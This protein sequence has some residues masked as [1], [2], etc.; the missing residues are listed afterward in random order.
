MEENQTN[1]NL[2]QQ[3]VQP[4]QPQPEQVQ[5]PVQ[6]QPQ[7]AQPVEEPTVSMQIQQLLVQQQQYQQ[8]YNQLVDYVKKTPN[9]PIEQVNQIKAQL[10][11]LNA[12]FVQGKQQL[13]ALWY[14]SVQ[15]NKPTNVKKW[16]KSN[17][18]FKKLAIWCIIVLLLIFTGFFVTLTSLIKN[19]DALQW[20]WIDAISAKVILQAFTWLLFWSILILMVW[21]IIGN[22]YRLIT[23]KN[24]WKI[25]YVMWLLGWI[26]WVIVFWVIMWLIFIWIEKIVIEKSDINKPIIQ[27]FL[28]GKVSNPEDAFK[29]QYDEDNILGWDYPLIAPSE[30]AFRV[31]T[32]KLFEYKNWKKDMWP[33]STI[34]SL[35]L[36]C[37]NKQWQRLALSWD[38]D[39]I[40]T[41]STVDFEWRCLYGEKWTYTYSL[42]IVYMNNINK[43][44][45]KKRIDFVSKK[46]KYKSEVLVELT[47]TKSSSSNN[48]VSRI[49]PTKWEFLLWK[50]PAKVTIDATQV[51]RDFGLTKYNVIW[52]LN[53]D[54][55]TDRTNQVNFDYYYRIPQVYY[56]SYKFPD[57]SDF[58]YSFPVRVE[59][60][61][62]PV[63]Y[64]TLEKYTWTTKYNIFSNFI[65]PSDATKI[66]SYN[67]TIKNESTRK[68]YQTLKNKWQ[69]LIYQFPEKWSYSV[70]LDYVTVD[71]K[72]WQCES[73][74]IW[75]EKETFDVQYALLSKN[76]ETWKFKEL[77]NSKSTTYSW[78]RQIKL[79]KMPQ[80][81]QLQIK[82]ISPSSNTLKKVVSL[83]G[84]SLLNEND[85]YTFEIPQE[86]IFDL[87][88]AISDDGRWMEEE[89][90]NIRFT[91]KKDAVVWI[92]TITSAEKDE[93]QRK[94]VTEWFEPLTVVIDASK[95]EINIEWDEIIYFTWDFGDW[96]I[97]RN[98][99]N[100]V[101]AHT[102]NYDYKNEN[103]IFTPKVSIRTRNWLEK[104]IVWPTLNVK[105]WLIN[106]DISA[107]SHPSRQAPVWK[108]VTF[109]AEFDWLPERMI[110]NFGDGS[111]PVTCKGRSCTEITHTFEDTW[112][113]SIK[114]SLEFDAV[115]Q[116]DGTMDFKVY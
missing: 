106:V 52:D 35:T 84:V 41:N 13:Q 8:Q 110:W 60:S 40:L 27:E 33:N 104:T 11:Q 107:T 75:L 79:N 55:K 74:I 2:N 82:S 3:P 1:Q 56:P 42:E 50:A 103:W 10:D 68:A 114:L 54:L 37:G 66:S 22:I 98:I 61:D 24:Q 9:L 97:K 16:A 77:C 20:I 57:L 96:E 115:Q 39:Q 15:V 86:W 58:I 101:V 32:S 36:I 116:V 28:V 17:F 70:I 81:Y 44:I 76:S 43:E 92:M 108:E 63:C 112:L 25:R 90:R 94:P 18:S 83:N 30:F 59:Q 31:D 12:L 91:A 23:V 19:P 49:Y 5:Q 72:Q 26:F 21:L 87:K 102:Y 105:K 7:P 93:S 45:L 53:E 99:Q 78:C 89:T 4:V 80:Q 88:M 111:D 69:E 48:K 85:T 67:Y 64:I 109:S 73:D 62:R 51:F 34:Q 14:T 6:W 71:G 100:W 38:I 29:F 46:L 47:T 95:T 113:F 65:D